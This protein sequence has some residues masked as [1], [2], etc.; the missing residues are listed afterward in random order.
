MMLG[1][2]TI[3]IKLL[4]NYCG[5]AGV[6]PAGAVVDLPWGEGMAWVDW[7]LGEIVGGTAEAVTTSLGVGV[8]QVKGI[9]AVT[10]AKLVGVGIVTVADFVRADVGVVAERTGLSLLKLQS[11]QEVA[12]EQFG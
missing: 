3:K 4:K 8:E 6:F 7:G 12:R 11:W 1:M 5:A 9:G 10:A 2:D